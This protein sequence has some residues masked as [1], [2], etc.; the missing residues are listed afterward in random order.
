MWLLPAYAAGAMFVE[1]V[2]G[3]MLVQANARNR[4][5]LSGL[6]DTVAWLC[7][8]AVTALTVSVLFGHDIRRMAVMIAAVSVANYAG[9]F[10]GV[11]A[12]ERW[13]KSG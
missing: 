12:G 13:I 10:V 2:I 1:D 6:L 7:Q 9:T 5:N 11:E 8:I 4:A 3:V